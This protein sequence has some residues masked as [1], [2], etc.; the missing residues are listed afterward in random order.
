MGFRGV[1]PV[2]LVQQPPEIDPGPEVVGI[3]VERTAIRLQRVIGRGGLQVR[4][5]RVPVVGPHLLVGIQGR[6]RG[7]TGMG[8][9]LVRQIGHLEVEAG[10]AGLGVPN[11][12][13]VLDDDP[14]ALGRDPHAGE[15]AASR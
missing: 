12:P 11:R 10:L 2:P 3:E 7:A 1:K 5:Q 4:P 9:D 8:G 14:V 13:A 6:A 15:R